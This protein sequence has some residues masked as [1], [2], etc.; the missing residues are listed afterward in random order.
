MPEEL[1]KKININN[2]DIVFFK[3]ENY[4]LK[5]YKSYVH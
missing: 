1:N 5:D 4:L 3:S 2:M